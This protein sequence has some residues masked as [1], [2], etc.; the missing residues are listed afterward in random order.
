MGATVT[1]EGEIKVVRLSGM[2][3][4]AEVDAIQWGEVAKMTPG[5]ADAKV[6]VL[7]I[8][9]DF[10]GWHRGDPWGDVRFIAKHGGMIARMAI[11][12]DP[13]WEDQFLMFTGAGFRKTQ[14]KYFTP[15]RLDEARAWL[16]P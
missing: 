9:E 13:V 1:N 8:A 3:R 7:V 4:K 10:A 14:I 11:V 16:Q 6:N 2:L 12:A 15:D 5:Q